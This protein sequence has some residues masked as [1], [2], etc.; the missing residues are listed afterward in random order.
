MSAYK[1]VRSL[2]R[3]LEVL[4]ALNRHNGASVQRLASAC[5]LHRTTVQR[6]LETL[7][8]LG[9]VQKSASDDQYRLALGVRR[10]T[11]GFDDDAWVSAVA[12][13]ALRRLHERILWPTNV[14]TLDVDAMLIRESTHRYSP[15]SIHHATV[16]QRLPMLRS[17]LGQAYLAFC[18]DDERE[19]ILAILRASDGPDAALARDAAFVRDVVRRARRSGYVA[20]PG[21]REK[22]IAAMALPIL[23]GERVFACINVVFFRKALS[24]PQALQKCLE[25]L[26]ETVAEMASGLEAGTLWP[27]TVAALPGE[28]RTPPS[29]DQRPRSRIPAYVER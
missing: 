9:Y 5:G 6:L 3:G 25:P 10:L 18:P 17:A 20:K 24:I 21:D 19:G 23:R 1:P 29:D 11:D 26:R 12:D 2:Q 16:G 15:F 28:A 22:R 14:A 8:A 27:R 4:C 13:P 7:R